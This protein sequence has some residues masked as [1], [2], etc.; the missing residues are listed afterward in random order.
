[1]Q[2]DLEYFIHERAED[3]AIV[4]LTRSSDLAIEHMKADYGID[5][6]VTILREQLPTGRIFGVEIKGRDQAFQD[7]QREAV[8]NLSRQEKNYFQDLPF[9]VCILFFTMADDKGYY[10]WLKYSSDSNQHLNSLEQHQWRSLNEYPIE[11]IIKEVN[12][13][14]DRKSHFAA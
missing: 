5:L 12:A 14:Y 9:P 8:I 13:W 1:M 4:H 7:I 6:L 3:L 2:Q 10:K 11:Q